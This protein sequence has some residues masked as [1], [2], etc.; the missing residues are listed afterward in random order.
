MHNICMSLVAQYLVVMY[1]TFYSKFYRTLEGLCSW[2]R[3]HKLLILT[4][5]TTD[6]L[7]FCSLTNV[8]WLLDTR[9]DAIE[10]KVSMYFL[11][12][13]GLSIDDVGEGVEGHGAPYC[14]SYDRES[15]GF[16]TGD[17]VKEK[18]VGGATA[19]RLKWVKCFS[20]GRH[21]AQSHTRPA[22]V[23]LFASH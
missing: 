7:F 19:E 17:F 12:C 16:E 4:T 14:R 2:T 20:R 21:T 9:K 11:V 5:K 1:S 8:S 10:K 15:A 22:R 18:C 3:E 23:R 6:F 13:K